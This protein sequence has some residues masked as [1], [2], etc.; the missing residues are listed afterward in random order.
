MI[1]FAE[2]AVKDELSRGIPCRMCRNGTLRW[3]GTIVATR[4]RLYR[5]DGRG[6]R[7]HPFG[8][9]RYE[10]EMSVGRPRKG[11]PCVITS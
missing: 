7:G 10:M 2:M 6:R 9:C 3:V 8:R 4:R 1:A 11:T 5:C